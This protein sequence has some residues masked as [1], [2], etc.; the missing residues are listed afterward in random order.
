MKRVRTASVSPRGTNSKPHPAC[1]KPWR[2]MLARRPLMMAIHAVC[3]SMSAGAA[4]AACP[5]DATVGNMNGGDDF[6][7]TTA[8][9]V[10][11]RLIDGDA[12]VVDVEGSLVVAGAQGVS[13]TAGSSSSVGTVTNHGIISSP[14]YEGILYES[15]TAGALLNTGSIDGNRGVQLSSSQVGGITN[16]LGG[17]ITGTATGGY[18]QAIH[19]TYDSAIV[20]DLLNNGLI[21][22]ST[23]GIMLEDSAAITGDLINNGTVTGTLYAALT[24]GGE[25]GIANIGGSV[26]N[27]GTLLG[28]ESGAH[29]RDVIIGLDFLNDVTGTIT[30]TTLNG[31]FL[32]NA[33]VGGDVSNDGSVLGGQSGVYVDGGGIAGNFTNGV[34]ATITGTTDSGV[35]IRNSSIG[36]D[37]VNDGDIV[38][39]HGIHLRDGVTIGGALVNNGSIT[40]TLYNGIASGGEGKVIV[41]SVTNN[42]ALAGEEAGARLVDVE[43]ESDFINNAE[44]TITGTTKSGVR[45]EGATVVG[46]NVDN[47]SSIQ[48][49]ESGI[50]VVDGADI[51]G[52]ILN[53]ELATITGTNF[54]GIEVFG[55]ATHV[56]A[57]SNAGEIAGDKGGVITDGT[58]DELSN[59]GSITSARGGVWV[60][61]GGVLGTLSNAGS[62]EAAGEFAAGVVVNTEG[63]LGILS[64]AG[65][66][67]ATG[68]GSAGV[69]NSQG[70]IGAI[71]NHGDIS[72]EYV[73]F[74]VW[75]GL[76]ESIT[77]LGAL[78]TIRATDASFGNESGFGVQIDSQA[79][80]GTLLNEGLVSGDEIGV[81]VHSS[82]LGSLD[83]SGTITGAT[84]VSF[85]NAASLTGTLT[86]SGIISGLAYGV[87]AELADFGDDIINTVD[88]LIHGGVAGIRLESVALTGS[89]ANGG[90]IQGNEGLSL[91]STAIESIVN[92]G[93]IRSIHLGAGVAIAESGVTAI[94]LNDTDGEIRGGRGV[95]IS[96]SSVASF[97]NRGLIVGGAPMQNVM[98]KPGSQTST[99]QNGGP[100]LGDWGLYVSSAS[101]VGAIENAASGEIRGDDDGVFIRASSVAGDFHNGGVI[102]GLGSGTN[103]IGDARMAGEGSGVFVSEGA[104]LSSLTNDGLIAGPPLG[105]GISI[106]SS[107]AV[108]V[109][110]N[111]QMAEIVGGRYGIRISADG[112]EGPGA[113]SSAGSISNAGSIVGGEYAIYVDRG[114]PDGDPLTLAPPWT[115]STIE[116]GINNT[117]LLDGQVELANAT[118]RL[119]GANARVTGATTGLSN[120]LVSVQGVFSNESTFNVGA[121][122]IQAE[123]RWN[124]QQPEGDADAITVTGG[125]FTNLGTLAIDSTTVARVTGDYIQGADAV[126]ETGLAGPSTYGRMVVSGT[127]TLPAN[128]RVV[129]NM[130]DAPMLSNGGVHSA[131]VSAGTL[132]S[133][134]TF[135]VSDDSVLFDFIAY[136]DSSQVDLCTVVAGGTSCPIADPDPTPDPIPDPIPPPAPDP[137]IDPPVSTGVINSVLAFGNNP[138]LGSAVVLDDLISII[139]PTGDLAIVISA[140]GQL[141]SQQ[142]V[143]NAVSQ[144]LPLLLGGAAEATNSAM[145]SLNR[146]I[147]SRVESNAGLSSGEQFYEDKFFWMKPFGSWARQDNRNSVF[148]F[149]SETAGMAVGTDAVVGTSSRI[150][151]VLTFADASAKSNSPIAPQRTEVKIYQL[152][153]YG[154]YSLNSRVDL[155]WQ[156][157][158][159]TNKNQGTRRIN[160]GA[161]DR[162]AEADYDSLSL[163]ASVGLGQQFSLNDSAT[164]TPSLRADYTHVDTDGYTETG[165]GA[166]NLDVEDSIFEEMLLTADVKGTHRLGESWNLFGNLAASYDL[167]NDQ[168]Q[169]TS[170]FVG[171]GSAFVTYGLDPSPWIMRAGAGLLKQTSTGYQ[172]VMRYDAEGRSSGFLNQSVSARVRKSF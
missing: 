79:A 142:E 110:T 130:V 169:S 19:V 82:S 121:A 96:D 20:G 2:P 61:S 138:G 72:G 136:S 108:G 8:R 11:C 156:L 75:G 152:V 102:V 157:D 171:G 32:G 44:A 53:R 151:A 137:T 153:G 154:S 140:L 65:T 123:S 14:F 45:F 93:T 134:G 100:Q 30:G 87:R 125:A 168:A 104:V 99:V 60:E 58:I 170:T 132:V 71:T 114:N 135:A 29:L 12:L 107:S 40:G 144:T 131:I 133:P 52:T 162:T 15:V 77:N 105:S 167:L 25:G 83:N 42:G 106:G 26:T 81:Q 18:G 143:S 97:V 27:T 91:G 150:G 21:T 74:G 118:L 57:I 117:G 98:A 64:N 23:H 56:A 159:G 149:R 63:A 73:G 90:V 85:S 36:G 148:G 109:I 22:G 101:S 84:G 119:Q 76:T 78:S 37:L 129:V 94:F 55:A 172:F 35:L 24:S 69:V 50:S 103:S 124:L 126:F 70:V 33:T 48:G 113:N 166:L 163:H 112:L 158:V 139:A 47:F 122:Q 38:G 9:T 7:I 146:I 141:T 165:A 128:A 6:S 115:E 89:I 28:A 39:G 66:I 34:D 111:S 4:M 41:D 147:Q 51:Q 13:A 120:S 67:A 54:Y 31:L 80:L 164:V 62:I 86:N 160:F 16:A 46:G 10:N 3:L 49:G 1:R 155:N 116:A 5:A 92:D 68:E 17:T 161:L 145:H 59:A 88:G 95:G 43:I 127:A